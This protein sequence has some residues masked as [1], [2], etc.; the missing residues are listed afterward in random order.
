MVKY[1]CLYM[2]VYL[3]LNLKTPGTDR[4]QLDWPGTCY[5]PAVFFCYFCFT[6][7]SLPPGKLWFAF[8]KLLLQYLLV[9]Q[10]CVSLQLCK[11]QSVCTEKTSTDPQDAEYLSQS[12]TV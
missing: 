5:C 3:N 8:Q 4:L 2:A 11:L 7:V 1:V 6:A 9:F 10:K 12:L